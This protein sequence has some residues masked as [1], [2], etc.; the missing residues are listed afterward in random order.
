MM[1]T[2]NL[3]F[4]QSNGN[5]IQNAFKV[6]TS[7]EG[8]IIKVKP[9]SYQTSDDNSYIEIK[10]FE[11]VEMLS[12]IEVID[13]IDDATKIIIHSLR[14]SLSPPPIMVKAKLDNLYGDWKSGKLVFHS[15][16]Y[17]R[18]LRKK[19]A[20]TTVNH[21]IQNL[22]EFLP[23][24]S[25]TLFNPNNNIT[26]HPLGV[27]FDVDDPQVFVHIISRQQLLFSNPGSEMN[28]FFTSRYPA[29]NF[30]DT[31]LLP[32]NSINWDSAKRTSK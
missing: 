31:T 8:D 5:I 6:K 16:F 11:F 9:I 30:T 12:N 24:I 19:L 28:A 27:I 29:W 13:D 32:Q 23:M 10:D 4:F 22:K 20:S 26:V 25:V 14:D 18:N 21:W 15:P 7:S 2:S 3:I 1:D 17:S